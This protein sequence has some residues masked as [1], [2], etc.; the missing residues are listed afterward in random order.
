MFNTWLFRLCGACRERAPQQLRPGQPRRVHREQP[1][2]A[3]QLHHH[4]PSADHAPLPFPRGAEAAPGTRPSLHPYLHGRT[5]SK[6]KTGVYISPKKGYFCPAPFFE[7]DSVKISPFPVFPLLP[8]IFA[9]IS[10]KSSYFFQL[11]FAW[12]EW[13][14]TIFYFLFFFE[15]LRNNNKIPLY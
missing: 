10:Y 14:N 7:N 3:T 9:V 2:G 15:Q 5:T 6:G 13:L 4:P 8:F 1:H 12:I 11:N